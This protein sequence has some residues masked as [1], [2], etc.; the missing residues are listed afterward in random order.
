MKKIKTYSWMVLGLG[1]FL[2][3]VSI[4]ILTVEFVNVSQNGGI[5]IIG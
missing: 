5:A 3:L 4:L 1:L 2:V